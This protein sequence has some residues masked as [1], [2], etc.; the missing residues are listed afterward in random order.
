MDIINQIKNEFKYNVMF[1]R[2]CI[3]GVFKKPAEPLKEGSKTSVLLVS[4]WLTRTATLVK[5][6]KKI[7]R[8]G[9]PVYIANLGFQVGNIL[10]K[11]KKISNYITKNDLNDIYIVAH[12]MGGLISIGSIILGEKRIRKIFTLGTPYTGS[13]L[14]F[15]LYIL[16]ILLALYGF[17][18]S[19]IAFCLPLLILFM[20]SLRQMTPGSDLI[21]LFQLHYPLIKNI[22]CI[23]SSIDNVVI[24]S[25][26][27]INKP[28]RLGR[29]EDICLHEFGHLNLILGDNSI[30]EVIK[31]L[32][33]EEQ[34]SVVSG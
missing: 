6:Q 34:K 25:P 8:A 33:I 27:K 12:S 10:K 18:I 20:P 31:L 32:E 16:I 26:L 11:S 14:I 15:F 30:Q 2:D 29:K 7:N 24:N 17:T 21:K 4:G 1:F 28:V 5:I 19:S 22:Q 3:K 13:Y 9:H 23:F